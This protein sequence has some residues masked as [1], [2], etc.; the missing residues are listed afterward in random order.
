MDSLEKAEF[1]EKSSNWLEAEKVYLNEILISNEQIDFYHR[2]GMAQERLK[3]YNSAIVSYNMATFKNNLQNPNY[4]YRLGYVFDTIGF[5]KEACGAFLMMNRIMLPTRRV[6]DDKDTIHENR[7]LLLAYI[8]KMNLLELDSWI[9]IA[10]KSE[11]L[12]CW[13]VAE[14]A[15]KN[16]LNRADEFDANIYFVLGN[17][18]VLQR[19]FEEASCFFKEQKIVQSLDSLSKSNYEAY[20]NRFEIEDKML[21]YESDY[22]DT[23]SGLPYELFLRLEKSVHFDT[24]THIWAVNDKE[25]INKTLRTNSNIIFITK[26]SDLYQRYL[27]KAKYLIVNQTKTVYLELKEEQ[28]LLN[29]VDNTIDLDEYIKSIFFVTID[30][31]TKKVNNKNSSLY[32][33]REKELFNLMKNENQTIEESLVYFHHKFDAE[34]FVGVEFLLNNAIEKSINNAKK[35]ILLK[36]EFLNI[37]EDVK[38]IN[39]SLWTSL[40]GDA[41]I[42]K[43]QS[44]SQR[45]DNSLEANLLPYQVW[46]VF[47]NLFIFARLYK[48]YQLARTNARDSILAMEE[49]CNTPFARYKINALIEANREEEYILLRNKLLQNNR[50]YIQK[51]LQLLGNSEHYFNCIEPKRDFYDKFFTIKEKAFSNY[52][53]NKSIA[54]VGPLQSGLNIGEEIDSHDVVLRFNYSGLKNFS[55]EEFG[56]KTDMSFYISEILLKDKLDI[57]KVSYMNQL[58]WVIMDTSHSEDDICFLGLNTNIRQRYPAGHAFATTMLKG[59]P[60]GIQRVIMDLLRFDTGKIKVFNTNLFLENNYAEAYRSRG[61]QGADHFNFF[62]HDPLSNFIFLKRLKASSTIDTD[63]ILSK[64]LEMSETEYIDALELRYGSENS[65]EKS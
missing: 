4:Y 30:A 35:W 16:Y 28:I 44:F 61:K 33:I 53:K 13:D 20:R 6:I 9:K 40:K 21:L 12:K 57:E 58:D 8:E 54:I 36:E 43:I 5:Y 42:N 60:S 38:M 63:E 47:S 18:L 25:K 37:L 34:N 32:Y 27:A 3:K 41:F 52:I 26:N 7:I 19:K 55:K 64:I 46:F 51:Y 15:Y 2:L 31:S 14:Y 49:I 48:K 23:V 65:E 17:I 1:Y 56:E 29:L 24:Y 22:G 50:V 59:A 39:V 45:C 11:A 10:E 62:W